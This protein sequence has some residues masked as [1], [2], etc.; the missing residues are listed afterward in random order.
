MEGESIAVASDVAEGTT[1][2]ETLSLLSAFLLRRSNGATI[3]ISPLLTTVK[4][5]S[6]IELPLLTSLLVR[7]PDNFETIIN[8]LI[9]QARGLV[10][11]TTLVLVDSSFVF[12]DFRLAAL[13]FIVP[14]LLPF[15]D[16]RFVFNSKI[17]R[18]V[19]TSARRFFVNDVLTLVCIEEFRWAFRFF[20]FLL[21]LKF[22]PLNGCRAKANEIIASISIGFFVLLGLILFSLNN[23]VQGLEVVAP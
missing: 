19:L 23:L 2:F 21:F 20:L 12:S 17:I 13:L 16:I 3:I 11:K 15:W 22:F 4:V 1:S 9:I 6:S 18:D 14:K 5:F 8:V 7:V 10:L